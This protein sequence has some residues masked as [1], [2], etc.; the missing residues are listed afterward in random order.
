MR[1]A[2]SA[3]LT[4]HAQGSNGLKCGAVTVT[5]ADQTGCEKDSTLYLQR[6]SILHKGMIDGHVS[7][8][9]QLYVLW[10]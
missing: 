2:A 10:L 3:L 6:A 7:L 1:P 9:R 5:Q 4:G 8:I